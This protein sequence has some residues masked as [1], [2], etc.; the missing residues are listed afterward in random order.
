MLNTRIYSIVRKEFVQIFRDPRTLA[1]IIVMP[2]MQLFLLGYAA[3]TDV[4]NISMAV[5]DQSQTPQSRELLD[6]FR[7]ADYFRIDYIVGSVDEYQRLIESGDI[8]VALV[9]PP[10]YA[11]QLTLGDATVLMV[12]DGSDGTI[13]ATALSTSR[14]IG[15]SYATKILEQQMALKGSA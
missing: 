9:I 5:W 3:T 4:K 8:R 11:Q 2:I 15:Q 6:A 1:L 12:L 14:L 10:D 13:G 7:A